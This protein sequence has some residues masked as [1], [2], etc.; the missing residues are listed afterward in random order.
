[1]AGKNFKIDDDKEILKINSPRVSVGGPYVVV[2]K[3]IIERWAIVALDWEKEPRLGIRWFWGNAGN[4]FSTGH[5]TWLII[6]PKL[7]ISILNGL[8][9]EFQFR[10]RLEDYLCGKV[11][12]KELIHSIE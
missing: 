8:P 9:I 6:P 7:V 2:Y 4:P 3:D 12:G 1:M 5:P 10:K 11:D